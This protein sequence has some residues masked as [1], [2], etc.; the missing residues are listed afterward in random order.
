VTIAIHGGNTNT[1]SDPPRRQLADCGGDGV[2]HIQGVLK[3]NLTT[4]NLAPLVGPQLVSLSGALR[5]IDE[6]PIP[7]FV[8]PGATFRELNYD[9]YTIPGSFE[10]QGLVATAY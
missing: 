7:G 5:L 9:L 8:T 4:L 3:V 2:G 10:S 1:L 6:G